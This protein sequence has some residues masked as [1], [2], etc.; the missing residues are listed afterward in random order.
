MTLRVARICRLRLV[1]LLSLILGTALW[2]FPPVSE[3]GGQSRAWQPRV[4]QRFTGLSAEE[5]GGN[6]SSGRG[7]RTL[8]ELLSGI[9]CGQFPDAVDQDEDL[10]FFTE[11]VILER[12]QVCDEYFSVIP[13]L[14]DLN[15]ATIKQNDT[16]NMFPLAYSHAGK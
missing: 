1:A 10:D 8:P 15:A 16:D 12:T 3:S 5:Q 7:A 6:I 11:E 13:P 4:L 2:S 14:A 9:Q